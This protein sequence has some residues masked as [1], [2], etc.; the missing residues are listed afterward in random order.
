LGRA[1]SRRNGGPAKR[2]PQRAY[3]WNLPDEAPGTLSEIFDAKD[4]RAQNLILYQ[5]RKVDGFRRCW[6]AIG[7]MGD[8][9]ELIGAVMICISAHLQPRIRTSDQ[10]RRMR[11]IAERA[12]TAATPQEFSSTLDLIEREAWL[13]RVKDLGLTYPTDPRIVADLRNLAAGLDSMLARRA[14]LDRGGR[15]KMAAFELLIQHLVHIFQRA[16]GRRAALTRDHHRA[17]GYSGRF[18]NFVEIVRPIAAE[19][20]ETSGAGLL[21]QPTTPYARG[22][23]IE[24]V[25]KKGR[26]AASRQVF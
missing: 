11:L 22:K 5:I 6:Q 15:S 7:A 13:W 25:L 21:A 4:S 10:R 1:L 20:I 17:E 12:H 24:E 18:W 26:P 16:S 2:L 19:I 23:Y 9:Y 14:L 3:V 8:P